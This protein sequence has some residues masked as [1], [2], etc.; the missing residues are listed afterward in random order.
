M[1]S[2]KRS[3]N[4]REQIISTSDNHC[5][6]YHQEWEIFGTIRAARDDHIRSAFRPPILLPLS[7]TRR[8]SVVGH[9]RIGT[10]NAPHAVGI[11]P[12]IRHWCAGSP[13]LHLGDQRFIITVYNPKIFQVLTGHIDLHAPCS[14][15]VI[16]GW[17]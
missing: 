16:C 2:N 9:R 13:I 6:Q 15:T 14:I 10:P 17:K 8:T 12:I 5:G 3:K 11:A 4:T 7:G 1:T